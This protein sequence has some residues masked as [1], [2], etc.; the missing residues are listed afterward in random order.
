MLPVYGAASPTAREN[1]R[2]PSGSEPRRSHSTRMTLTSPSTSRLDRVEKL[3]RA[4]DV[5]LECGLETLDDRSGR[6]DRRDAVDALAGLKIVA[7][8]RAFERGIFE[9]PHR[10]Q[11]K[12]AADPV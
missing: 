5:R 12:E 10:A 11:R 8:V 7:I 3:G 1:R 6:L 2:S 4:M 9:L